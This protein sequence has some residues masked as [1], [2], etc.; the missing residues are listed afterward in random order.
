MAICSKIW[1]EAWPIWTPLATPMHRS[2]RGFAENIRDF[3]F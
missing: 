1:G 2:V 3:D